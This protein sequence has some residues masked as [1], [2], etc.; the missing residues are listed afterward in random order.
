MKFLKSLYRKPAV[1]GFVKVVMAA[2]I[3]VLIQFL[4]KALAGLQEPNVALLP[5]AGALGA[6]FEHVGAYWR[7]LV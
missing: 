5:Q 1:K 6:I 2:A 7:R 3:P 4:T